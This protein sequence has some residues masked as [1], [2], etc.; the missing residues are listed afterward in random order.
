M[1]GQVASKALKRE[2]S[3]SFASSV[4]DQQDKITVR[5]EQN[6]QKSKRYYERKKAQ[7]VAT[8]ALCT[9]LDSWQAIFSTS[10]QIIELPEVNDTVESVP[11]SPSSPS[12]RKKLY[13]IAQKHEETRQIRTIMS[14]AKRLEGLLKSASSSEIA[15]IVNL[16]RQFA[17][18]RDKSTIEMYDHLS[19]L[20]AGLCI[21]LD[22][23]HLWSDLVLAEKRLADIQ[24]GKPV[25]RLI[26]LLSNIS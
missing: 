26:S 24:T 5:D 19:T 6:R 12:Q 11:P 16:H 14:S 3:D 23:L 15:K 22:H 8:T 9:A 18:K 4:V 2:R 21:W 13:K 1:I 10:S 25:Q 17:Q 20:E 7:N